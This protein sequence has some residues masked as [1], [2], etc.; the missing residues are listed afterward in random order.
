[1]YIIDALSCIGQGDEL[2]PEFINTCFFIPNISHNI[3][4]SFGRLE[5]STISFKHEVQCIL[6]ACMIWKY[7][8][9]HPKFDTWHISMTGICLSNKNLR[10]KG[11]TSYSYLFFHLKYEAQR[12]YQARLV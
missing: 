2:M 12:I 10:R 11:L 5:L 7:P 6:D 3:Y 9:S 1:M 8:F 4:L